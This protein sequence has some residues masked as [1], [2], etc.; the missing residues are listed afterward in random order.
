M[1]EVPLGQEGRRAVRTPRSR[2]TG[3]SLMDARRVGDLRAPA[4]SVPTRSPSP[5]TLGWTDP[6]SAPCAR[7]QPGGRGAAALPHSFLRNRP[8]K[9]S[10]AGSV[11]TALGEGARPSL[12][13]SVPT[14][15]CTPPWVGPGSAPRK[16]NLG[17]GPRGGRGAPDMPSL[18]GLP[19]PAPA[20][21]GSA[22]GARGRSWRQA[23]WER[24]H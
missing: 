3:S 17:A 23:V 11:A 2:T 9:R 18:R 16:R 13:H 24:F 10:A 8:G 12:R 7:T 21:S 5:G 14:G 1:T 20:S 4:C 15:P 6:A 19:L 22:R